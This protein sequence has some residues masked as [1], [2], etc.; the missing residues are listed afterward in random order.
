MDPRVDLHGQVALGINL[1]KWGKP[2][3]KFINSILTWFE[4]VESIFFKFF[5]L[6]VALILEFKSALDYRSGSPSISVALLRIVIT[7]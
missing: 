2:L 1:T 4:R 3:C 5:K 6:G 7:Y